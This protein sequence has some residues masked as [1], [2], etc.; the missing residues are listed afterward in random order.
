MTAAIEILL[1]HLVARKIIHR[2]QT[3]HNLIGV[4][5]IFAQRDGQTH[6]LYLQGHV[7]QSLGIALDKLE[8]AL[9]LLGDGEEGGK[10]KK[11]TEEQ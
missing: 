3:E 6:A 5:R 4:L 1:C 11:K 2:A 8:A 9:L 10:K 7:D